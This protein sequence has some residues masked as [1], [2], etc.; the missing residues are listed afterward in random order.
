M[1]GSSRSVLAVAATVLVGSFLA[2]CVRSAS[3]DDSG[4]LV[5]ATSVSPITD[6]AK[7]VAGD[8][9]TVVGLIP[10]GGDRPPRRRPDPGGG[11]PPPFR[12][13]ARYRE[14]A[15]GRGPHRVE[16]PRPRGPDA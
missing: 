12:A 9:A 14:N 15:L 1:R 6:I 5:V 3:G 16:R 2:G 10:E 11:R 7:N 8:A 13:D 4:K